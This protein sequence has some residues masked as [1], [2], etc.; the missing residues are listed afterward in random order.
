VYACGSNE[1]IMSAKEKLTING[2]EEQDFFSDA[3][4]ETK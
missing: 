3:F 1:M 4:V 2:L